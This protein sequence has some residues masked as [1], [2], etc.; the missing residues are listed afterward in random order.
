MRLTILS[1]I[2]TS[3]SLRKYHKN[4]CI[5]S[6]LQFP[7]LKYL[8]FHACYIFLNLLNCL[9]LDQNHG[10]RACIGPLRPWVTATTGHRLRRGQ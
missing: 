4:I 5:S 3:S 1:N 9:D 10:I 8:S 7:R 6:R 2:W